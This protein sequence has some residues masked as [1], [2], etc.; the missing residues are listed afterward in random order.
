MS[1]K[2]PHRI[3]GQIVK[4]NQNSGYSVDV[5]ILNSI[6]ELTYRPDAQEMLEQLNDELVRMRRI[7]E[8]RSKRLSSKFENI[9]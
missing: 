6:D 8:V 3:M 4:G 2:K 1:I 9:N 5:K 7:L